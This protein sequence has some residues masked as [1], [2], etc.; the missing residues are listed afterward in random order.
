MYRS[1][2]QDTTIRGYLHA[3]VCQSIWAVWSISV[4]LDTEGPVHSVDVR[5]TVNV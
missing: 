3:H 2:R 5:L 4:P 1:C